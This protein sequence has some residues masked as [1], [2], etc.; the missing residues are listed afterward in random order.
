MIENKKRGYSAIGLH[1]PKDS[2]NIGSVLRIA[3]NYQSSMVVCSGRRYKV[4]ATDTIKTYR[5]TPFL[6]VVDLKYVIPY[7]C[8]P[9][10]VDLVPGAT[11]LIDYTHPLRA[12]Y[13]FGPEDGTLQD[14]VLS[15]CRD[16]IYIPTNYCMNLA[17]TVGVVLYDR[18]AKQLQNKQINQIFKGE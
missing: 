2:N 13:I 5:H 16:K 3:G 1:H 8:V 4:A 17:V 14:G 9:V 18:L 6:Q 11:S 7:D 12:F 10:A 15:W